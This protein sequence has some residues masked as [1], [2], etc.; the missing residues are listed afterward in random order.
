[1]RLI[2]YIPDCHITKTFNVKSRVYQSSAAIC[3]K[4]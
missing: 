2:N 3:Q 4:R 1:M